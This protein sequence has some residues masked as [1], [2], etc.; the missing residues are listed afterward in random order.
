VRCRK[1][2]NSPVRESLQNVTFGMKTRLEG[3]FGRWVSSSASSRFSPLIFFVL[4]V[5]AQQVAR[6]QGQAAARGPSHATSPTCVLR[7]LGS[8]LAE[9]QQPLSTVPGPVPGIWRCMPRHLATP[10]YLI[11]RSLSHPAARITHVSISVEV[12]GQDDCPIV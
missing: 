7:F 3:K 10:P 6:R 9:P 4:G 11:G 1:R 5:S 2:A 8:S 12:K